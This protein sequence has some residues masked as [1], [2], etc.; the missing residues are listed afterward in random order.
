MAT[1]QTNSTIRK[2]GP[3]SGSAR[4]D[5]DKT[6]VI[7]HAEIKIAIAKYTCIPVSILAIGAI[8]AIWVDHTM[9]DKYLIAVSSLISGAFGL[10]GGL[11]LGKRV[12]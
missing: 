12:D 6:T 10:W 4:V 9:A 7:S 1:Q 11:A 8:V 3:A 2:A 5:L